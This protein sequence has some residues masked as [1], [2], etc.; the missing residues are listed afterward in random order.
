MPFDTPKS[1][2]AVGVSQP[3]FTEEARS[4]LLANFDLEIESRLAK[5]RGRLAED[6]ADFKRRHAQHLNNIPRALR[7]VTVDGFAL[8]YEGSVTRFIEE[9]TRV[10]Q[11][12][13][14]SVDIEASARKR[15]QPTENVTDGTLKASKIARMA[16]PSPTKLPTTD[17]TPIARRVVSANAGR[18]PSAKL[19]GAISKTRFVSGPIQQQQQ[20]PQAVAGPSRPR[21]PQSGSR[22][23]SPTKPALI[24][25]AFRVPS[26]SEFNPMMPPKTPGYPPRPRPMKETDV[27]ISANGSPLTNPWT[28]TSFG[29]V[30]EQLIKASA[31]EGNEGGKGKSVALNSQPPNN[32]HDAPQR[33]ASEVFSLK[34]TTGGTLDLDPN[35][36][37]SKN[38]EF[39]GLT[40]S[41]KKVVKDSIMKLATRYAEMQVGS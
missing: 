3:K 19:L 25:S 40:D 24:R 39:A 20:Q 34:T 2:R 17:A 8:K 14:I 41:A 13:G 12:E 38:E 6:L 31:P 9:Q 32:N 29:S 22:P 26:A 36:S 7:T 10:K 23:N 18:T 30:G 11:A 16:T 21:I 1:R 5:I 4:T 15:K 37:P 33:I 27:L 35:L 28:L